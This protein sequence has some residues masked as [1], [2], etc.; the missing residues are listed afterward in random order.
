MQK[1]M[2]GSGWEG[3]QARVVGDVGGGGGN[4][5]T[6]ETRRDEA[7]DRDGRGPVAKT[8]YGTTLQS[9]V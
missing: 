3:R 6:N 8:R 9:R 1:Q 2:A 7:D 5:V 4:K